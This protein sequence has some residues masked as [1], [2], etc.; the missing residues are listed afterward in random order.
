MLDKFEDYNKDIFFVFYGIV[1][2]IDVSI[3]EVFK[4]L[5]DLEEK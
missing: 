1:K 2:E 5:K 4:K 3:S